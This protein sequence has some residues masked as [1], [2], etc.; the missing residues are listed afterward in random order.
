MGRWHQYNACE[1]QSSFLLKLANPD[2]FETTLV[3]ACA[4]Q[5]TIEGSETGRNALRD[6]KSQ[7]LSTLN[8]P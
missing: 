2:T 8:Y 4:V 7:T 5:N 1:T 3:D 6:L